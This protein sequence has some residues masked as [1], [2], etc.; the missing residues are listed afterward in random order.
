MDRYLI[1][2]L[3]ENTN[4]PIINKY[5]DFFKVELDWFMYNYGE[6]ISKTHRRDR[7]KTLKEKLITLYRESTPYLNI[8]HS[9]GD[10][11]LS[12][13]H[14][15]ASTLKDIEIDAYSS[16]FQPIGINKIISDRN[17][18]RFIHKIHRA[19]RQGKFTDIYNRD[20]FYALERHNQYLT[21]SY[22]K[23]NFRGL[24]LY[25]DEYF[26]SKYLI[27]IFKKL[28]RP[29]FIFSHGLPGIYSL[30][31]DNR[32]DYLMVWGEKIKD[33]YIAAGFDPDKIKVVGNTKYKTIP[34]NLNLRNSLDDVLVIP[35]SS[36]LWHQHEW[37]EPQLIDRSMIVLYLYQVQHILQKSGVKSARFRP[38]P[39]ID[40]K[41][42][43][44]FLD[45]TF[46]KC[47]YQSLKESLSKS[48][49]VIGAT[50]TTFLESLMS[51][52][53]YLIYEPIDEYGKG[54]LRDRKVPPFDGSITGMEIAHTPL[55][56]ELLIKDEYKSDLNILDGYM[57]P[58]DLSLIK[59]LLK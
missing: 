35:T 13:I 27:D 51:G 31:V 3:K 29:S 24:F 15:P 56:L 22:G 10:S 16:I 25:T 33:N 4:D 6:H 40:W 20:F 21:E 9:S 48:T 18:I 53:N 41:W 5:T 52:V 44:G 55:E 45:N 39:S 46:Y 38:H 47:D 8:N 26:E 1:N 19:V 57:Q 59:T 7:S 17:S 2:Y 43:Y 42:V 30:D 54:I 32:S 14:F 23:F 36:V 49:L 34:K 28:N 50:S 37:G 58:L 11:V 12:S